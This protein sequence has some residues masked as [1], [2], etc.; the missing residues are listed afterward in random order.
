MNEGAIGA[1]GEI[2]G[3]AAEVLTLGYVA[4]QVRNAKDATADQNRL[5]RARGVREMA[6]A[7]V[8]N[9][10]VAHGQIN[11][12][13]L[14]EY[15]QK[16]GEAQGISSERALA[17]DW[18]NAYYFGCTRDSTPRQLMRRTYESLNTPSTGCSNCQA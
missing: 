12:W 14:D 8:A 17:V 10:Q 16:L 5:E 9:P 11:N 6:L 4:I 18:A 2:L 1:V 13:Q 7:M 15:Y 3:A